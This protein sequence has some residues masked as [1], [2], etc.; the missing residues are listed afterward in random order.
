MIE[1]QCTDCGVTFEVD[2]RK[3]NSYKKRGYNFYC[4]KCRKRSNR[5]TTLI[6]P[7]CGKEFIRP[8]WA[9]K[10]GNNYFCS[11]SC[12]ATYNNTHHRCGEK[13]PN[14]IDGRY[15]KSTYAKKAYR[16]YKLKCAI[17]GLEEECCLQVHHVDENREN[18]D[19]NNLI[20]LCANCHCRVHR[21]RLKITK[22]IL[23][24]REV[25]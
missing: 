2:A 24:N 21:G 6:C 1:V 16:T 10:E 23:D 13:N 14:W 12:A 15:S 22:E 17:C 25:V 11:K 4:S 9:I 19:I 7:V 5:K 8:N 3:Y 20:I 18:D